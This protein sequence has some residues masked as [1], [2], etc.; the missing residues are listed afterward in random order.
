MHKKVSM[1]LTLFFSL[2]YNC[3][4]IVQPR[5]FKNMF[6]NSTINCANTVLVRS[7]KN[8]YTNNTIV[9]DIQCCLVLFKTCI[10]IPQLHVHIIVLPLSFKT[11]IPIPQ[12]CIYSL[13]FPRSFRNMYTNITIQLCKNIYCCFVLSKTINVHVSASACTAPWTALLYNLEQRQK[14]WIYFSMQTCLSCLIYSLGDFRHCRA[15][16]YKL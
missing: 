10:P 4:Y 13:V 5:S 9:H 12:L 14:L 16:N 1:Q 7:F 2:T 11:C 6:S 3:A 15:A 8:M